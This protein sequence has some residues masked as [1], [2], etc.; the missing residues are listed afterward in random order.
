MVAEAAQLYGVT[1]GLP[2]TR[3]APPLDVDALHQ[4]VNQFFAL[5]PKLRQEM[6]IPI[7]RLN[8]AIGGR[9][10]VDKAIDLGVALEALLLHELDDNG[11]LSYRLKT[12]GAAL[13]GGSASQRRETFNILGRLYN[14]RSKAVHSG[15]LKG[16]PTE[17]IRA[18]C[19]LCVRLV[20]KMIERGAW[21]D[22]DAL[23]LG[24]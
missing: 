13:L 15:K 20:L 14:L 11:E 17:E 23:V 7:D 9:N 1:R 6:A 16:N 22:W 18:G 10:P 21:P 8:L 2:D 19:A 3:K 12:R 5:P 4:V 24:A